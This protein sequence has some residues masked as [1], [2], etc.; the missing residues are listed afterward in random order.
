[1]KDPVRQVDDDAPFSESMLQWL[2]EGDRMGEA[3]AAGGPAA[4]A[5][6]HAVPEAAPR[7]ERVFIAAGVVVAGA[8]VL[9]LRL[10]SGSKGAEASAKVMSAEPMVAAAPAGAPP[11]VPVEPVRVA[12]AAPEPVVAPPVAATPST[13]EPAPQGESAAEEPV[14]PA[15]AR[16]APAIAAPAPAAPLPPPAATAKVA[17]AIAAPAPAASPPPAATAKGALAIAGPALAAPTPPPATAKVAAAPASR[18]A[19]PTSPAPKQA[20]ERAPALAPGP[21]PPVAPEL[22]GEDAFSVAMTECRAH[23]TAGHIQH[24]ITSCRRATD[25]RPKSPEALTLLAEAEFTRGHAGVALRLATS[26]TDANQNFADAYVIIGG[27]YQN[28]GKDA[29]ARAAY[30]QYLALAPRGRHAIDLR[31]ILSGMP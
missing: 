14:P 4:V 17:P 5:G 1:M 19:A 15:A 21:V 18:P 13:A 20:P 30:E 31:A 28:K 25:A 3:P 22:E 8:L 29:E 9:A 2:D 24:A 26:A 7:R 11:S 23:I 10:M 27:I 12:V 16:V 6:A